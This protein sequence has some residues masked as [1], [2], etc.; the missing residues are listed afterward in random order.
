MFREVIAVLDNPKH[1]HVVG[2]GLIV[3]AVVQIIS[4]LL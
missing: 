4:T 2:E 3:I 1:V